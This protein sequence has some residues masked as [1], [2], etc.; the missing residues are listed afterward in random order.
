MLSHNK[1]NVLEVNDDHTKY[2]L[3]SLSQNAERSD[4]VKIDDNSFERVDD[5]KCLG[6]TLKN[7]NS[8]E[9][10]TKNRW[11]SVNAYQPPVQNFMYSRL[12]FKIKMYRTVIFLLFSMN[13]KY[14]R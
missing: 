4:Y 9:R 13:E 8:I 1:G 5:F 3:I 12:L 7:S 14:G 11:S 2:I 6:A 10:E